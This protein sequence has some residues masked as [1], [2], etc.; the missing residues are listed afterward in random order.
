MR[1]KNM[2]SLFCFPEAAGNFYINISDSEPV[3]KIASVIGQKFDL[4]RFSPNS[5][6]T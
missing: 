4:D 2:V 5:Q 1:I 3:L 6:Q